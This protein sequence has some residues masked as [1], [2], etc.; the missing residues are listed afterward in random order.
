MLGFG[1]EEA[2]LRAV[3]YAEDVFDASAVC[4][5]GV[6]LCGHFHAAQLAGTG[7]VRAPGLEQASEPRGVFGASVPRRARLVLATRKS[8]AREREK[9]HAPQPLVLLAHRACV[10]VCA[11]CRYLPAS[12]LKFQTE[13]YVFTVYARGRRRFMRTF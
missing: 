8:Q 6:A 13:S 7:D 1:R 2:R 4:A 10:T 5:F 9:G 12:F 11:Q 3:E